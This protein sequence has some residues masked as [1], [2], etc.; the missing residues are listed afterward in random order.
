MGAL[1]G[2]ARIVGGIVGSV[3]GGVLGKAAVEALKPEDLQRGQKI[4]WGIGGF[5]FG[6]IA[7]DAAFDWASRFVS[8]IEDCVNKVKGLAASR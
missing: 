4:I 1:F 8:Q 7:A 2:V 3:A 6:G 5:I